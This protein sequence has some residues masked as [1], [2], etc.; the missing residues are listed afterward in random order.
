[1]AAHPRSQRSR[2]PEGKPARLTAHEIVA[3]ILGVLLVLAGPVVLAAT[4][5]PHLI[6]TFGPEP[7][8][9]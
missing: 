6:P 8:T 4:L 5:L 2:E 9:A 1:M 7:L 3:V